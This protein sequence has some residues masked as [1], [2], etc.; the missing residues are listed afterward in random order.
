MCCGIDELMILCRTG[1][2]PWDFV[3]AEAVLC[4]YFDLDEEWR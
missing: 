1:S 3:F 4:A 2:C